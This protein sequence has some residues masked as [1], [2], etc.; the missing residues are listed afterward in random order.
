[1][2]PLRCSFKVDSGL[3]F[4]GQTEYG[5]GSYTDSLGGSTQTI[6]LHNFSDSVLGT[7]LNFESFG[8]P[9]V[10]NVGFNIPTGDSTWESKQEASNIP[11]EFLDSRYRGRGFGVSGLYGLSLPAGSGQFGLAAGYLYSGAFNPSYGVGTPSS[12][13]KLGDSIFLSLTHVQ[14]YQG[15]KSE[16]V[17]VSGFYF[18]ATQNNGQNIFQMGPNLNASYN[19]ANPNAMSFEVGVQAYLP[20]QR[21][22]NGQLTT[23]AHYSYGPR[24]YLNPLY[25]F[26]D[27]SLGGRLKY[28]LAN[29]YSVTDTFYDGGGWLLGVEPALRLGLDDSSAIKFSGDYDYIIQNNGGIDANGNRTNVLYNHWTAGTSFEVKL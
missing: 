15:A 28:V 8:V 11:T 21:G 1:L 27:F 19:W 16:I 29:G 12:Q 18:L 3:G 20:A 5:Y 9:S 7:E 14:T 6:T 25:S 26:G 10:F 13:L 24:V 2:A 4:Y 22:T 23:E 17:R